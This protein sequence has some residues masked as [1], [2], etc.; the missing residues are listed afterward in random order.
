[1]PYQKSKQKSIDASHKK[2]KEI[3]FIIGQSLLYWKNQNILMERKFGNVN[4]GT[5]E[6]H[7]QGITASLLEGQKEGKN[8][9]H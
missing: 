3:I 4:H 6:G 9:S 1:M 8:Y 7:N 5:K 2:L